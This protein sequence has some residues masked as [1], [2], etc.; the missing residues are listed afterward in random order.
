MSLQ[1]DG[2]DTKVDADGS[3]FDAN[4][5]TLAGWIKISGAGE[6]GFGRIIALDPDE[7][8][9]SFL[10]T[11]GLNLRLYHEWSSNA[12]V[13]QSDDS[14]SSGVWYAFAIIFDGNPANDPLFYLL[15]YGTDSSLQS[16]AISETSTPS[17]TRTSPPDGWCIGNLTSQIRG[18]DGELAYLQAWSETRTLSELDDAVQNPGTIERDSL[19]F[20]YPFDGDVLDYSPLGQDGTLTIG[21]GSYTSN[22]P[23]T[24][25]PYTPVFTQSAAGTISSAGALKRSTSKSIAGVLPSVGTIVKKAS[26]SLTGAISPAGVLS[27]QSI[28]Q[29]A[30]SGALGFSGAQARQAS[31]VVSGALSTTGNALKTIS[32]IVSGALSFAGAID[33]SLVGAIQQAVGGVLSFAGAQ[34]RQIDRSLTGILTTSG[35]LVRSIALLITGV[36]SAAGATIKETS[37]SLTGAITSTGVI[38]TQSVIQRAIGGALSFIGTQSRLTSKSLTGSMSSTGSQARKALK[39]VSGTFTA[40]GVAVGQLVADVIEQAVGGALSF[41]GALVKAPGINLAGILTAAGAIQKKTLKTIA[42]LLG[43]AGALPDLGISALVQLTL[44]ARSFLLTLKSRSFNLTIK[45]RSD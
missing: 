8:T 20:Y 6:S 34:A 40:A 4:V 27:V 33:A 32:K 14:L 11:S 28:V 39:G 43:F 13:W 35:V 41:A 2:D 12:G 26:K 23:I 10:N 7:S 30:I 22:P 15:E 16:V 18:F 25:S 24:G 19:I 29:R 5:W 1:F 17:G 37:K 44:K 36:L 3:G 9:G 31:K 42:G 21:A 38:D 45:D